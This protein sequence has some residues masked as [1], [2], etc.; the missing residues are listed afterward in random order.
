MDLKS[1]I[2][3]KLGLSAA[4]MPGMLNPEREAEDRLD[5]GCWLTHV[6]GISHL[7][8]LVL[9]ALT[10]SL[11]VQGWL[12]WGTFGCQ[13]DAQPDHQLGGS[14]RKEP[15][16]LHQVAVKCCDGGGACIRGAGGT[17]QTSV[18]HRVQDRQL[19]GRRA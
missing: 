6:G 11:E 16:L 10:L 12:W 17:S 14:T 9:C 8:H 7:R 18:T 1:F 3:C 15:Q 13:Q 19:R 5:T 2:F 4:E